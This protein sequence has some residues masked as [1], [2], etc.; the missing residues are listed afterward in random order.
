MN[1]LSSLFLVLL[2]IGLFY[3]FTSPQYRDAQELSSLSAEYRNVIDNVDRIAES[4]DNLILTSEQIPA[5]E[6]ERLVKVLPPNVDAVGLAR[7][8]DN[9]AG[10]HGFTI[11][12][13][14]IESGAGRNSENV[15][16]PEYEADYEKVTVSFTFITGYENF[17]SFLADLEKSLRVM[18]VKKVSFEVGESELYEHEVVV[19]TYWLK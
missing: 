11:S 3:T 14:E 5:V 9:I 19:E 2:A 17:S 7:D 1:K 12:S 4:R 18:D 15:V 13:V 6:K 16:L 8:L 10:R